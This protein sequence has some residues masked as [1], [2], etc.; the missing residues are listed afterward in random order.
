MTYCEGHRFTPCRE[1]VLAL[2]TK[3]DLPS[4]V[5]LLKADETSVFEKLV[6]GHKSSNNAEG[7]GD[8]EVIIEFSLFVARRAP[9]SAPPALFPNRPR[10]LTKTNYINAI[11]LA[12]SW[13][14]ACSL[15]SIPAAVTQDAILQQQSNFA[16]ALFTARSS[17]SVRRCRRCRFPNCQNTSTDTSATKKREHICHVPG[18]GKVYSKTSHLKAHLLSHS[19]ERPFVCN[20]IFCNKA[21]TRSDELQRHL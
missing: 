1:L 4:S 14:M 10:P 11:D 21:F 2:I 17:L 20:W 19:G 7:T 9:P 13:N 15:L 6:P 3:L 18:C 12:T 8:D 5:E 16:A